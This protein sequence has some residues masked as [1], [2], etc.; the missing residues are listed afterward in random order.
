MIF[1]TVILHIFYDNVLTNYAAWLYLTLK[2][3][4]GNLHVKESVV[5]TTPR[6]P[7]AGQHA[8]QTLQLDDLLATGL[9]MTHLAALM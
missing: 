3:F 1:G 7:L 8:H 9:Y 6:A 2:S 5:I 4:L